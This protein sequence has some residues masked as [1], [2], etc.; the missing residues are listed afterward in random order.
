[1]RFIHECK[2][3]ALRQ[4]RP[5]FSVKGQITFSALRATQSLPCRSHS[6]LSGS[7][8]EATGQRAN[9]PGCTPIKPQPLRYELHIILM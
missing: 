8:S 9:A 5:T 3:P 1:M 2:Q 7:D 6:P 4:G